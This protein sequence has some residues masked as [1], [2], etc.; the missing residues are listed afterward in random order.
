MS[1]YYQRSIAEDCRFFRVVYELNNKGHKP[2]KQQAQLITLRRGLVNNYKY[3]V[4]NL[5]KAFPFFNIYSV[6]RKIVDYDGFENK[7]PI[8][9]D[10]EE[11]SSDY[12]PNRKIKIIK[13]RGV[14]KTQKTFKAPRGRPTDLKRFTTQQE[15]QLIDNVRKSL[16]PNNPTPRNKTNSVYGMFNPLNDDSIT[17]AS[18]SPNDGNIEKSN[19]VEKTKYSDDLVFYEK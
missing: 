14:S 16:N 1:D 5:A 9:Y 13:N 19:D 18:P 3:R 11:K 15:Q 6:S 10:D 7:S 2:N 17:N 8:L 4:T 12:N